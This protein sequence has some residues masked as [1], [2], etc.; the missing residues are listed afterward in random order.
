MYSAIPAYI[1]VESRDNRHRTLRHISDCKFVFH[2]EAARP[3]HPIVIH[4]NIQENPHAGRCVR[5]NARE[6]AEVLTVERYG[7]W[8]Y[9]IPV[10]PEPFLNCRKVFPGNKSWICCASYDY[11]YVWSGFLESLDRLLYFIEGVE[12]QPHKFLVC[13]LS[14]C[15]PAEIDVFQVLR[16]YEVFYLF[17]VKKTPIRG[18]FYARFRSVFPEQVAL[19]EEFRVC[20]GF[21]VEERHNCDRVFP[22]GDFLHYLVNHLVGHR[23]TFPFYPVITA[24][25]TLRV[26]ERKKV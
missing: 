21:P 22:Q 18:K 10:L 2:V 3:D 12:R 24:E 23:V 9:D 25:R 19:V 16:V 17:L 4:H 13:F 26:A 7:V 11:P 1:P 15:I 14:P 20:K 6:P 8:R 5:D